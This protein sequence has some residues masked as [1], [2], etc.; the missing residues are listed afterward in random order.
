MRPRSEAGDCVLQRL[1]I[2]EHLS[3][4][5]VDP[6]VP[7]AVIDRLEELVGGL[8]GADGVVRV[9]RALRL[10]KQAV[11][12]VRLAPLDTVASRGGGD[13]VA[14]ICEPGLRGS[15]CIGRR[16]WRLGGSRRRAG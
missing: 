14:E 15:E 10:G 3:L 6:V 4:F 11:Q 5:L 9:E 2:D 8:A 13:R 16:L 12:F 1:G 7:D